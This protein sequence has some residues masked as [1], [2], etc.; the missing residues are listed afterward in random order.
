MAARN[1]CVI[2]AETETQR[3]DVT[4]PW[5]LSWK[6]ATAQFELRSEDKACI[7]S[8]TH[9][10][11]PNCVAVMTE[12]HLNRQNFRAESVSESSVGCIIGSLRGGFRALELSG[13]GEVA[14]DDFF[15]EV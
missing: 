14:P 5:S 12:M 7:S 6:V 9:R 3:G 4:S 1:L 11:T 10:P 13:A 8:F 2:D 15:I